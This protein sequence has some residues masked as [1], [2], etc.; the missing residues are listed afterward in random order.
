MDFCPQMT[1]ISANEND[2]DS[3]LFASFTGSFILSSLSTVIDFVRFLA[4]N[5]YENTFIIYA[6]LQFSRWPKIVNEFLEQ[7]W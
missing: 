2:K 3:R 6:T 4:V 5:G 1:R 7:T